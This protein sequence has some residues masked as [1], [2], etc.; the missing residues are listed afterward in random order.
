MEFNR[1]KDGIGFQSGNLIIV[2]G[3]KGKKFNDQGN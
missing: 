3:L 2:V 1:L